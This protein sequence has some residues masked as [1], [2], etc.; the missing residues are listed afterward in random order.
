MLSDRQAEEIER[1][2][3]SRVV[4]P[5]VFK[6]I[7]D[8]LADRRERVQQLAHLR[9]RLAQAF[10]YLDGLTRAAIVSP[11]APRSASSPACPIC[12]RPYVRATGVSPQ[13]IVYTHAD[14]RECRG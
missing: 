14:A 8:L 1:G 11:P 10:R 7:D 6:W 13:G 9:Q 3:R 4:G 2:R 12:R 5:I